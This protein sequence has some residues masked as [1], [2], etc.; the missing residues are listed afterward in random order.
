M[1]VNTA[2]RDE[3]GRYGRRL[4]EHRFSLERAAGLQEEIYRAAI[5]ARHDTSTVRQASVGARSAVLLARHKVRRKVDR[6]KGTF[7]SDDMNAV[8]LAADAM[9]DDDKQT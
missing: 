6:L 4:A 8:T 1:I 7:K 9:K 5:A 3:L 2:L